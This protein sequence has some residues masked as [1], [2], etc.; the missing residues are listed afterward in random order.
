MYRHLIQVGAAAVT[1]YDYILSL[2]QEVRCIW[3]RKFSVTTVLFITNRYLFLVYRV[4]MTLAMLPPEH[5]DP[6]AGQMV[7]NSIS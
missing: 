6:V 2:T 1:F 7:P 3:G 5:G 4:L